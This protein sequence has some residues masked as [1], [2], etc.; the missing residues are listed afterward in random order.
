MQVVSYLFASIKVSLRRDVPTKPYHHNHPTG[1][2]I[3]QVDWVIH[4]GPGTFESL[5]CSRA[6]QTGLWLIQRG[7]RG[8]F[9]YTMAFWNSLATLVANTILSAPSQRGR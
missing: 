2:G 4:P 5:G 8:L 6:R 9:H 7:I 1:G 3:L